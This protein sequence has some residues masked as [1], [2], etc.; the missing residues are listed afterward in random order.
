MES[1]SNHT[2]QTGFIRTLLVPY[3]WVKYVY[4]VILISLASAAI[5]SALLMKFVWNSPYDQVL[6][7]TYSELITHPQTGLIQHLV[8]M[9]DWMLFRVFKLKELYEY[10]LIVPTP[11]SLQYKTFSFFGIQNS[12][13]LNV[14][15]S[16]IE[17]IRTSIILACVRLG[18]VIVLLPVATIFLSVCSYD[19][20]IERKIR[21]WSGGRESDFIYHR[22]KY[23]IYYIAM[24][25]LSIYTI[26]P[27]SINP[28][29]LIFAILASG[30]LIFM[31]TMFYKKYI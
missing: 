5:L 23:G 19:G 22:A 21:T 30:F 10:L 27:I 25:V 3:R 24:A 14:F 8:I 7:L 31:Q 13:S 6:H 4:L 17:I 2:Q 20:L 9:L 15:G 26:L 16:W 28:I 1:N 18:N 29:F 11:V 12:E